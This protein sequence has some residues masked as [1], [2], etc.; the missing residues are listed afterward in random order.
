LPLNLALRPDPLDR[1]AL[2]MTKPF[3]LAGAAALLALNAACSKHEQAATPASAASAGT[4]TPAATHADPQQLSRIVQTLASEPFEGRSAGTPGEAKTAEYLISAFQALGLE[5]G[6]P[7][8]QFVQQVPLVNTQ[9][10]AGSMA[11]TQADGGEALPLVQ[12]DT[13]N[14]T[15][16]RPDPRVSIH[17]APLV[18]VGYGVE[19]PDQSWDDYKG[20]DLHGKVAV[21]L[22]NDPD[23]EAQP[24]EDAAGR[25]GGR[26]MS[27]FGRWTY[28]FAEAA[29]RGAVAAL[30]VH[31]TEGAGYGW[32]TVIANQGGNS[33]IVRAPGDEGVPLQ[34]WL[35]HEASDRLFAAAGLD[36]SRLRVEARSASFQPVALKGLSFSA[37]LPVS[38]STVQSQNFLARLPGRTHPEETLLFGA[39]WDAY[40]V[41]APDAQ[42][43]TIRPGAN[44]DALGL[45]GVLELARLF[46]AAAPTDRTLVFA[47]WTAEERGLLGSEYYAAH[48]VY[49]LAKTVAV[50]NLDILQ[51]AGPARNVVEVGMGNSSLDQLLQQAAA[52]Q[53]RVVEAE[54]FVERG[55]FY[56]ADH[57]PM[58]RRGVPS[59][60]LMALGGAPDLQSGGKEAGQQWL[61][62]YMRCY[63]QT[64]DTWSADWDL[65]GA[66]QDV[67]LYYTMAMALANGRDWPQWNE[68]VAFKATRDQ[69]ADQR[70]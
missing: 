31:D 7:D 69:S 44:D 45:A 22:I 57:F 53:G 33:D 49:P 12:G 40:G 58:A 4:T 15:T 68:G 3:A 47:A 65:R 24:G 54:T 59:V 43:R 67:D 61:D 8:G 34:G 16:V 63:H 62:A 41:G 39:H 23:F 13:I 2:M 46:K 25:F 10:G 21:F 28:K 6:G 60:L 17:D 36:L 1:M 19:A 5:P 38:V 50:L 66:A 37:D 55:L 42:G 11:I 35:A 56:R 18:F 52:A 9:L 51:T 64:C 14:V 27:Y 70:P 26:R 20:V 29:R 32:Q 30:I 48:P